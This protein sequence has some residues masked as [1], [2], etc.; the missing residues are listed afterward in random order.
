MVTVIATSTETRLGL[1]QFEMK[2]PNDNWEI[3]YGNQN[4]Y[5][6]V[7]NTKAGFRL[8]FCFYNQW[9]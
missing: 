8:D 3:H 7:Q 9:L 4:P 1:R 2:T 6:S 5:Q